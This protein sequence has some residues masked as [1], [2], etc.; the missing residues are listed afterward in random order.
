MASHNTWLGVVSGDHVRYAVDHGFI[1]VNHG[2]RHNLARM[3]RG[4]GF[5]YYSPTQ[6]YGS[7]TPLRAFTALGM[8]ADDE[9]YL[10]DEVT[11]MGS[12]GI[13]RPWRRRID[14]LDVRPVELRDVT[15]QLHLTQDRNWGYRLRLGCIPLAVE[16][17]EVLH[18][19]MATAPARRRPDGSVLKQCD[20]GGGA[21]GAGSR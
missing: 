3:R 18:D 8:I 17:F 10:A 1:Q 15:H 4:D 21:A 5:V 9:P 19:A 6:I 12:H 14:Y 7:K 20:R 16:D 13:L 11:H 2:K